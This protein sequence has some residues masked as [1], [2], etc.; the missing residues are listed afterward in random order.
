MDP[1][2]LL[3]P[4]SNIIGGLIAKRGQEKT[5]K[6]NLAIARENRAFQE[7]MSSTAYQR[8]SKDLEKAGL[9][10]ILA[11]GSSAS[12]PA[13]TTATMQNPAAQLGESISKA[14]TTA[15][16]ARRLT[17][18]VQ[19]IEQEVKNKERLNETMQL[20]QTLIAK[21]TSLRLYQINAQEITNRI[22]TENLRAQK[23]INS[24]GDLDRNINESPA[25]TAIRVIERLSGSALQMKR[26]TDPRRK[27]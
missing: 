25:G 7:R 26:L 16:A 18:D 11:L 13:G 24:A 20:Q 15:L 4:A 8:S 6:M 10:R 23:N 22:L 17:A 14:A 12:T 19:N 9:N 27:K 1:S 3:A 5:N 21:D 2:L